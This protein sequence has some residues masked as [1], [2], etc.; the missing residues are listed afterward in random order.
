METVRRSAAK[1]LSCDEAL[2]MA[3]NFA[4]LP[5]MQGRSEV[6]SGV[7]HGLMSFNRFSR[8]ASDDCEGK[9]DENESVFHGH[10][11]L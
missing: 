2:R 3:V 10:I 1:L 11:P 4:K 7:D 6:G 8:S 9:G 5:E